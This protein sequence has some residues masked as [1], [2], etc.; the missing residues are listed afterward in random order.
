ML[1]P[2]RSGY[3]HLPMIRDPS[4]NGN[5]FFIDRHVQGLFSDAAGSYNASEVSHYLMLGVLGL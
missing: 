3:I 5:K 1:P 2:R 4:K